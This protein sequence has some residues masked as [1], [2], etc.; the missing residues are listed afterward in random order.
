MALLERR[1]AEAVAGEQIDIAITH[2]VLDDQAAATEAGMTGSPTLLIDGKDPFAEPDS[3]PSVSCRLYPVEGGGI[4]GAPSVAALRA[5]LNLAPGTTSIEVPADPADCCAP[6][7]GDGSPIAALGA[8]RGAAQPAGPAERAI[9]HAILRTFATRGGPP[10]TTELETVAA[11]FD[12]SAQQI[13]DRL[14]ASDVIRLDASGSID[15][16]YPFSATP[17]AHRVQIADGARVYAMCAID[18]L[19]MSAMLGGVEVVID[20][21]DASTGEHIAVTVCGDEATADPATTVV[22]IGAQSA[23]GPSAD[24]CC[25]YLNFFTD[26]PAADAW[27]TANPHIGGIV[28]DLDEATQCGAAIFGPSSTRDR[29]AHPARAAAPPLRPRTRRLPKGPAAEHRKTRIGLPPGSA[30]TD[31]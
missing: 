20:S 7:T 21:A 15:A 18:A 23:Q 5:A 27:A 6:A 29:A 19:G 13:L 10:S 12:S 26:R 16:V 24:T 11:E 31:R 3:V 22:F 8:W 17:T 25:N 1:I 9:H 28:V 14:H 30:D 2:R 4:D